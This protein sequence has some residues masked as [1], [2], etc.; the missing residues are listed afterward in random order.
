M[1]LGQ[2][3]CRWT[4]PGCVGIRQSHAHNLSQNDIRPANVGVVPGNNQCVI[5]DGDR[6]SLLGEAVPGGGNKYSSLTWFASDKT[7]K[8][9]S[10]RH[11][12]RGLTSTSAL[13]LLATIVCV[14]LASCGILAQ[15]ALLTGQ[16]LEAPEV[17]VR[18][19]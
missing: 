14:D 19:Q 1:H 2:G 9:A 10:T 7:V 6:A 3:C 16:V 4:L 13:D 5:F 12:K 8:V 17:S 11:G 18:C 15:R